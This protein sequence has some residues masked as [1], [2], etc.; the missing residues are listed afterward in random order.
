MSIVDVMLFNLEDN[1]EIAAQKQLKK[2]DGF[3]CCQNKC[4]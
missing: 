2:V 4:E 3:A 1:G